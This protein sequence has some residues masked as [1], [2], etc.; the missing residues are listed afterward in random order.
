[1][2]AM[3]VPKTT[4]V[5]AEFRAAQG[6]ATKR[7]C[8][9]SDARATLTPERATKF[10]AA[11]ADLTIQATVIRDVLRTW[12]VDM[13]VKTIRRHRPESADPCRSCGQ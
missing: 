2:E 10:D 6:Q 12:G 1:M 13:D 9:A 8:G 7:R 5:L 11:L 3:P 4:D